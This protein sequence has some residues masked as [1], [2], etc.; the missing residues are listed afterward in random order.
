MAEGLRGR[1]KTLSLWTRLGLCSHLSVAPGTGTDK[2]PLF[3]HVLSTR[4]L[5]AL[6][7]VFAA[8][9]RLIEAS[10][11]ILTVR[12]TVAT[13]RCLLSLSASARDPPQ[14]VSSRL[15]PSSPCGNRWEVLETRFAKV[16]SSKTLSRLSLRHHT[17][18]SV[19]ARA[20]VEVPSVTQA[21]GTLTPGLGQA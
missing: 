1:E 11:Q 2:M 12:V 16:L 20:A 10:C 3:P 9:F 21:A 4:V 19:A 8:R 7:R 5:D 6:G 13:P 18:S 14:S 17:A 15:M